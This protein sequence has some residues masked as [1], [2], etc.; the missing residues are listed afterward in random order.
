MIVSIPLICDRCKKTFRF[1]LAFYCLS[2]NKPLCSDCVTPEE[3][4]R[5]TCGCP[6]EESAFYKLGR[7][8]AEEQE[9]RV[10]EAMLK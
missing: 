7:K 1:P 9:R 3:V 6:V 10:L 8:M 5:G 4:S 2:C